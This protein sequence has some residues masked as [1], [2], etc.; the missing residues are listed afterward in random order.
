MLAANQVVRLA[1]LE[2]PMYKAPVK[3][4]Y[5]HETF[6]SV[7]TSTFPKLEQLGKSIELAAAAFWDLGIDLLELDK[8]LDSLST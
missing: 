5:K 3:L 8:G 2:P 4:P 1:Q 7:G 6:G